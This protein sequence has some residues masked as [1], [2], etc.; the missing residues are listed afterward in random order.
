MR[1]TPDQRPAGGFRSA[2]VALRNREFRIFWIAALISNTGGW[3]QN[4]AVPYVAF[5]LTGRN[6]GVG[7]AGFWTY[8]PFMVAGALGGSLADR[9]DRKRLLV[10]TQIA[11]AVFAGLLWWMVVSDAAT[12]ARLSA[13]TF[14]SGLASGLNV[15]VW[16]SFVSQLV[17]REIMLNAVTLNSTQFNAARALGTFLAGIVIS[18]SGAG[19]VFAL[20][21][22]S[23]G[24]VLVGLAMIR[25]YRRPGP[26]AASTSVLADLV[27][28]FRYVWRT[29]AIVSCCVAIA[30]IAGV[31]S[32]LFSFL[33]AS[34]G[35]QVF[36]V[37]GWRLALLLGGGGIGAV[38]LAPLVLTVGAR[39]SRKHLLVTSMLA[40]G[41]ATALVGLAPNM[42][43]ALIGLAVY[44]GSYLAI[45][46]AMN[47]T[48]QLVAREDMRGKAV[49]IYIMCLTGA[50]PVGLV[51]WGWAADVW[52]VQA[53]TVAAGAI[54]VALTGVFAA[55]RRFDAMVAADTAA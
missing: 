55:T 52:G 1:T 23:F 11:Q 12:P 43:V 13:L 9:F 22:V 8:F 49:A 3:M 18:V 5:Q 10:L 39:V 20:N 54:L 15:P 37:D 33:P 16:Q 29:P 28:G 50:L 42:W 24:S 31:A 38:L 6:G 53:V 30:S 47:T 4:A 44:G 7:A 45:A 35:Q 51:V 32:P 14:M 2:T 34:Y 48:I 26:D 25:E 27:A 41:L 19:V 36:D 17:P 21:A 40:Y 46:S